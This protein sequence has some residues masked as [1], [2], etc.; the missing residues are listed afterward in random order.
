MRNN[1]QCGAEQRNKRSTTTH[2]NYLLETTLILY[3]T[4]TSTNNY[5]LSLA[6]MTV[7]C[8]PLEL[9]KTSLPSNCLDLATNNIESNIFLSPDV[10]PDDGW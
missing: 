7:C 2:F 3:L 9:D 1:H 6:R 8:P 10:S 4:T 5:F